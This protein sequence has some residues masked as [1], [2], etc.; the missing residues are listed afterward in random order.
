VRALTSRPTRTTGRPRRRAR[1]DD[2]VENAICRVA[3]ARRRSVVAGAVASSDDV[4]VVV[5][6]VGSGAKR[7][8]LRVPMTVQGFRR[9]AVDDGAAAEDGGAGGTLGRLRRHVF[10]RP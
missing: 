5:V 4:V 3:H 10:C 1:G 6:V 2:E 9:R 7:S 8:P